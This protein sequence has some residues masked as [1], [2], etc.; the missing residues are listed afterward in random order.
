LKG[1]REAAFLFLSNPPVCALPAAANWRRMCAWSTQRAFN[2]DYRR[3]SA[4]GSKIWLRSV[5]CQPPR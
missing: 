4:L 5:A 1:R 2:F 3:R